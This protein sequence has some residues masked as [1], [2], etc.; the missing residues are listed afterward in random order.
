[1]KVVAKIEI[2]GIILMLGMNQGSNEVR[3]SNKICRCRF[4]FDE[5][6]LTGIKFVLQVV[7]NM[8]MYDNFKH[9][10]K[11]VQNRQA[12]NYSL[13]QSSLYMEIGTVADCFQRVGKI[14]CDKLRLKINL[15]TGIKI[16]EPSIIN[17]VM[18][19]SPTD[20]DGCAF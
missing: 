3:I 1:M 17:T 11:I 2:N 20:F 15:R 13:W 12:C 18:P 4:R 9:F 5:S 14:C 8:L 7:G 6:M 10:G 16:S 19:T